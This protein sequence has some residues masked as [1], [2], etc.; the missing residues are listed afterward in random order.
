[1]TTIV[2]RDGVMAAD[3]RGY[4]GTSR[5]FGE[6]CKVQRFADARLVGASSTEPGAA[7]AVIKWLAQGADPEAKLPAKFTLLAVDRHGFAVLAVDSPYL[8]GPVDAPYF[9]IGSGDA[10][11]LGAMAV[12]ADAVRA[13]EIA[14][15]LDVW[16]SFPIY[17]VKHDERVVDIIRDHSQEAR[18]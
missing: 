16:S 12:G 14:I 8:S 2:Y 10:Y 4:S 15:G 17:C 7:E 5:P 1:M 6:R 11:A 3:S 18:P 13:C 9:A